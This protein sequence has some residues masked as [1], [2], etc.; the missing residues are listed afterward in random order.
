LEDSPEKEK[1]KSKSKDKDKAQREA[2]IWFKRIDAFKTSR[3]DLTE[4]CEENKKIYNGDIV[5]S[6]ITGYSK[7]KNVSV[8][9]LYVDMKQSVSSQYAK[10]PKIYFT[11][12][13]PEAEW[14]AEIYEIAVNNLWPKLRMKELMRDAVKATKLCGTTVFKTYFNFQSELK[15]DAYDDS[16]K[17]DEVRTDRLDLG[18]V[19][20]DSDVTHPKKS[21]WVA[22]EVTLPLNDIVEKF[23]LSESEKIKVKITKETAGAVDSNGSADD[24]FKY[25]CF[26]EVEDRANRMMFCLISGIDKKFD[27]KELSVPYDSMYDFLM[28][29]DIPDTKEVHSDVYFWKSQLREMSIYRTMMSNHAK[30]G[31]AKYKARGSSLTEEQ[32][33]QL[34]SSIDSSVVQ[35]E[36]SQ[37]IETFQHAAIDPLILQAEGMARGDIQ[38]ISKQAIRQSQNQKTATEVKAVESAAQQVE[39]ENLERLEEVMASIAGKWAKLIHKNYTTDRVIRL[40]EVTAAE[41]MGYRNRLNKGDSDIISGTAKRGYLKFNNQNLSADITAG[42]R[43]GSTLP[44]NEQVR[45]NK[46]MGF[47]K[48]VSTIPG[49]AAALDIEEVI[50]EG[51]EVFGVRNMNL[52]KKKED[53]A[54]ESKLL[55]SGILIAAKLSENHDLHIGVHE[56]ES[57]DNYQNA[58]H[59]QMHKEFK[60]QMQRN[61]EAQKQS[62]GAGGIGNIVDLLKN[63]TGR[64]FQGMG[65]NLAQPSPAVP[66][67]PQRPMPTA[68]PRPI[69]APVSGIIPGGN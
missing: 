46:F 65:P 48:F 50:K 62:A 57:N 32:K 55:N 11:P 43:A 17:N 25:G 26:Y 14:S 7:N 60:A 8:N 19:F 47:A 51:E 13:T 10:N 37:D 31:T 54:A 36:A 68:Q 6:D 21:H 3:E 61:E 20:W 1:R 52:L 40:T 12:E 45:M 9:L 35:L 4:E 69:P 24:A 16:V 2:E 29:N 38:L 59:I 42:V 30:K 58:L 56:K 28:Y 18:C 66:M 41:F 53:P 33:T 39:I 63:A 44:D 64:S 22:H 49:A 34:K 5:N 27:E 67:A 23:G 15:K